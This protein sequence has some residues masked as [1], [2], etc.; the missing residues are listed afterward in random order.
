MEVI[1]LY[2]FFFQ[3]IVDSSFLLWCGVIGCLCDEVIW[4]SY[5][6]VE[7]VLYLRS[8]WTWCL[9]Y[10]HSHPDSK[11]NYETNKDA[12][13]TAW[14]PWAKGWLLFSVGWRGAV[15]DFIRPLRILWDFKCKKWLICGNAHLV[16]L[17]HLWP[18]L[19]YE[20]KQYIHNKAHKGWYS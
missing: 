7:L 2:S 15:C 18:I 17:D 3:N 20:Y 11:S 9:Q 13:S 8:T 1:H 14:I 10:L 4:D 6:V 5:C 16:F 12:A 19:I